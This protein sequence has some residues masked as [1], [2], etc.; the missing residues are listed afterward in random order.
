[1][2]YTYLTAMTRTTAANAIWLQNV[3]PVWVFLVGVFLFGERIHAGDWLLV[4]CGALGVGFILFFEARG[5]Q[6]SG[7]IFGLL[8]GVIFA[9][10]VLCVRQ[11]RGARRRLADHAQSGRHGRR[12]CRRWWSS[13]ESGRRAGSSPTRR[14]LACCN[15]ACR[16]SC[17]RA[18]C[19]R[20]PATKRP[21]SRCW[22][23]SWFPCGC[24]WRGTREPTLSA[25]ALVDVCRWSLILFGL[26]C[27]MPVLVALARRNAGPARPP[28]RTDESQ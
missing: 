2:N 12:C 6:L 26:Y 20:S 5:E 27:V 17:L 25:A 4:L 16:T 11:L 14:R 15:W 24:F 7:V 23:R 18:A 10:V 13:T 1:M 9:G 28:I 8:S 19:V 3:A 21:A 22:S